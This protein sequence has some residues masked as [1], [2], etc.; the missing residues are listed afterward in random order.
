MNHRL[1]VAVRRLGP[2][3]RGRLCL[4]LAALGA[5]GCPGGPIG[6]PSDYED[7]NLD[8]SVE[9]PLGKTSGEPN[10][11]FDIPIVAVFDESDAAG[12]KGTVA[13][14]DDLDVFL[15]GGFAAGDRIIVDA[16]AVNS[17]DVSIAVFDG[18][19]RLAAENDDRSDS[20]LDA[21]IDFV[22]RHDSD[23]YFLVVTRSAFGA[24]SRLTGTYLVSVEAHRGGSTPAPVQQTVYL[25][26][27]GGRVNSPRLGNLNLEPFDAGDIHRMYDG[28]TE[29][30]K[31]AIVDVMRQNYERFNVVMLSSDDVQ[32]EAGAEGSTIFFGGSN[33]QAY[34][35]AEDVDL[36][37]S[38]LCDDAI[39]YTESFSPFDFSTAPSAEEMGIAIG[40]VAAHEAGHLLGL[41]HVDN[42]L[43]LMD[44]RSLADAFLLDQEFMESL[45]STDIM[46]IGTQDSA[47]LLE[48]IVGPSIE[49]LTGKTQR[50]AAGKLFGADSLG[51]REIVR[52]QSRESAKQEH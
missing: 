40:N 1:I 8:E 5:A 18:E 30:M 14:N 35:I 31:Q 33:S 21:H 46:P 23:E 25:K 19:G 16:D 22:V 39:I 3:F 44:D 52:R 9:S 47:L 41:N 20:D 4:L 43:D 6:L 2:A 38:S 24:L 45:L 36:Y 10:D 48:E 42:D 34:G 50:I 26:F 27:D 51:G 37:N 12:L 32:P 13:T 49:E 15:L 29:I 7:G 11:G 28:E 17:L